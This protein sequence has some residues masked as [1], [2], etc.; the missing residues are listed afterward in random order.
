MARDLARNRLELALIAGEADGHLVSAAR[1]APAECAA[2]APRA[3]DA[4]LHAS[5]RNHAG[6][7]ATSLSLRFPLG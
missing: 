7:A 6:I 4:D 1:P 5:P 2:H 3:D